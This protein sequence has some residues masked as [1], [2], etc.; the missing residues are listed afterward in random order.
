MIRRPPRSTL[1]PYTTL[2]RA[3][4][5]I[6]YRYKLS[7]LWIDFNKLSVLDSKLSLS[8]FVRLKL[9]VETVVAFLWMQQLDRKAILT[10]SSGVV[11][12]LG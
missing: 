7:K 9:S 3:G 2:F 4:E 8:S 6:V 11:V 5:A 10:M 12:L 1:F